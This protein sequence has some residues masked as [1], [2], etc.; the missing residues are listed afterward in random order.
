M[1]TFAQLF[2]LRGELPNKTFMLIELIGI[3]LL[4]ALWQLIASI[5]ST[6]SEDLGQSASVYYQ[7][8]SGSGN[9]IEKPYI[10]L[11]DRSPINLEQVKPI[12]KGIEG[13][14][15]TLVW[16]SAEPNQRN[17]QYISETFPK[18]PLIG[19]KT[20]GDKAATYQKIADFSGATLLNETYFAETDSSIELT[21]N[22]LGR[23]NTLQ[24][25]ADNSI[26]LQNRE[27]L[28]SNALLPS[29]I[30]VL[31][32]F[33][34]LFSKDNLLG[35]LGFSVYLN[36]AGYILATLIALPLGFLI[37]LFPIFR[38]LFHR[39]IDA[40]RFVPL[41]A[42][43][44]LFIAWFGIE[45]Q[46]KVAFLAFGIIVYLLPVV[47]QRVREVEEVYVQT[48]YTLGAS[49]WQQIRSVF[50]PAVLSRVSD[51]VRVL[52][53]ISWTYIIVAELVNANSG[54]IGALAFK[55][56]RQS[57]IDKVFAI[58][59][60]IIVVGFVQDKLFLLLDRFLF[61]YKIESK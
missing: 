50:I 11:Y 42:V 20:D 49:K 58:L 28:I 51:D 24:L 48:A 16:V 29:P 47:V 43:T 14:G 2:K 46:M 3:V 40:L 45:T 39:N 10:M 13:N 21:A 22:V 30:E 36:L 32:S 53:A 19:V 5:G 54:G 35:N 57:H 15:T 38:A 27:E 8:P 23:V 18:I 44:G 25:N 31:Q 37:G 55:S 26:A 34:P 33:K 41:T 56:A 6:K 12:L 61:P 60:I 7:Q 4:L 52:V 17:L 1:P 9:A 59:L